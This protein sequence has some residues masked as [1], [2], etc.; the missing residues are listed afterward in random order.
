MQRPGGDG[1]SATVTYLSHVVMLG[2]LHSVFMCDR[3]GP[4]IWRN[5]RVHMLLHISRKSDKRTERPRLWKKKRATD[6]WIQQKMMR[7]HWIETAA[8]ELLRPDPERA[9]NV[10]KHWHSGARKARDGGWKSAVRWKWYGESKN[11]RTGWSVSLPR[12]LLGRLTLLF[13]YVTGHRRGGWIE[14]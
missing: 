3:S 13:I 9:P 4:E 5:E 2:Q 10:W 6:E 11:G 1:K 12:R 7:G 14:E 8:E